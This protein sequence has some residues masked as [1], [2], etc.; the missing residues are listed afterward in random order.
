MEGQPPWRVNRQLRKTVQN[1]NGGITGK[2]VWKIAQ[3]SPNELGEHGVRCWTTE[4]K[5]QVTQKGR[6]GFERRLHISW[7]EFSGDSCE[8]G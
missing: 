1:I 6:T 4:Q 8:K 2:M 5:S 3:G 7:R